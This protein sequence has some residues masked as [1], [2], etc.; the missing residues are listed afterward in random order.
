MKLYTQD[1]GAKLLRRR[2]GK[3][4]CWGWCGAGSK[5][6]LGHPTALSVRVRPP[7]RALPSPAA[8]RRNGNVERQLR[9]CVGKL[10]VAYRTEPEGRCGGARGGGCGV[11]WRRVG[12]QAVA[13]GWPC[14][15]WSPAAAPGPCAILCSPPRHLPLAPP[16]CRPSPGPSGAHHPLFLPPMVPQVPVR[17][18]QRPH[19]LH[20]RRERHGRGQA[21]RAALHH[22]RGQGHTGGEERG[23]AGRS[24]TAARRG[25]AS[26]AP[27]LGR[28]LLA[29][30]DRAPPAPRLG[31]SALRRP[32][33]TSCSATPL[34]CR[35]P[36]PPASALPL[37]AH[38][39]LPACL[40]AI[41]ARPPPW[42][43]PQV[44]LEVDD[45]GKR[46]LVLRVT[47]DFVRVQLKSGA[48][49]GHANEELLEMLRG[50]LGALRCGR[51]AR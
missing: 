20:R 12:D 24:L 25:E 49:A 41:P 11:S 1:G 9:L 44:A 19:H 40:P 17:P 48:N 29:S 18:R 51:W 30:R 8:A 28:S 5:G 38:T 37:P 39:C 14:S 34:P 6:G 46:A 45:R 4:G 10:P 33:H 3:R 27:S 2:C 32:S 26:W 35:L 47:A 23:S 31:A 36:P 50:V 42:L 7:P 43:C 13:A 21:A 15:M 16:H 22:P